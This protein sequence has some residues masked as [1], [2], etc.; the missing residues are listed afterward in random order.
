MHTRTP[1]CLFPMLDFVRYQSDAKLFQNH[2]YKHMFVQSCWSCVLTLMAKVRSFII[3]IKLWISVD[4]KTKTDILFDPKWNS[5]FKLNSKICFVGLLVKGSIRHRFITRTKLET[6][7]KNSSHAFVRHAG[8]EGKSRAQR[9]RDKWWNFLVF[10]YSS[11]G[12]GFKSEFN[13]TFIWM[14]T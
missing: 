2:T 12:L 9:M 5:D 14:S 7:T 4:I 10:R 8:Q 13:Y 3:S 1:L 11:F 6:R